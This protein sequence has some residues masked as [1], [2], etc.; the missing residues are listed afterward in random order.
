MHR[1]GKPLTLIIRSRFTL[2][3]QLLRRSKILAVA[4]TLLGEKNTILPAREAI[5]QCAL[6]A[7]TVSRKNS[8]VSLYWRL[9]R[10]SF[11]ALAVCI[12]V[13]R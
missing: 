4:G 13:S 12:I 3:A 1:D 8:R 9:E 11:T 10:D 2:S 7:A 5:G 6:S